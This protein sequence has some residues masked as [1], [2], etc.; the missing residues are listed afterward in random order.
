V[1]N[2]LKLHRNGAVGCIDWLDVVGLGFIFGGATGMGICYKLQLD[3][4]LKKCLKT[5]KREREPLSRVGNVTEKLVAIARPAG[6]P[7]RE[8]R[9]IV[10][11][12]RECPLND[13]AAAV[14]IPLD[15]ESIVRLDDFCRNGCRY[16]IH[17]PLSFDGLPTSSLPLLFVNQNLVV[18]SGLIKASKTS[19]TGLRMSIAVF[20]TGGC[21]SWRLFIGFKVLLAEGAGRGH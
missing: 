18:I 14:S 5:R 10:S 19:A 11:M 2:T 15:E 16:V 3:T 20:A 8:E 1:A 4:V 13:G 21:V 6:L 12:R 17:L 7:D 9:C